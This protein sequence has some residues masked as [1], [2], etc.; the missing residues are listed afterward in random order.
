MHGPPLRTWCNG[1]MS[2][3]ASC[4]AQYTSWATDGHRENHISDGEFP[5][6]IDAEAPR[7]GSKCECNS[8]NPR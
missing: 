1:S 7:K 8:I 4:C 5:V 3:Q 6:L 2:V